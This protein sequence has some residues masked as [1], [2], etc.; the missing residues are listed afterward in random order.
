MKKLIP[1]YLDQLDTRLTYNGRYR[2]RAAWRKEFK[3]QWK[4]CAV[5]PIE[6]PDKLEYNPRPYLWVCSCPAFI[7]SRFLICKHL[8]QKVHPVKPAFFYQVS[9]ERVCPIWRH[10][11]LRPIDPPAGDDLQ[12]LSKPTATMPSSSLF[13]LHDS[14][15]EVSDADEDGSL[16]ASEWGDQEDMEAS[17]SSE[18][19][20]KDEERVKS[21]RNGMHILAAKLHDLADIVDYNASFADPRVEKLLSK[22]CSM[23]LNTHQNIDKKENRINSRTQTNLPTFSSEFSDIILIHTRP[24]PRIAQFRATYKHLFDL[25]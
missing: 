19:E 22:R 15:L 12:Q 16:T 10:P 11:D 20:D 18:D 23:A 13:E 9:R 4:L 17:N 14:E 24:K 21:T 5:K 7:K 3:K 6:D 2:K 25:M 8:V 1:V